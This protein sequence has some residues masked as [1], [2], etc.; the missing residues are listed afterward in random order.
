MFI[1]LRT[2]AKPIPAIP[3]HGRGECGGVSYRNIR[4]IALEKSEV[5]EKRANKHDQWD[6]TEEVFDMFVHEWQYF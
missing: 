5:T 2:A 3:A 4:A 6:A 1:E